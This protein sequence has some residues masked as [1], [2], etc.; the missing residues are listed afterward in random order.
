[1]NGKRLSLFLVLSCAVPFVR[2][3]ETVPR[4]PNV[5]FIIADDL[6]ATALSCYGNTL[7]RTPHIDRLAA[8][9]M[10]FTRATCN[11][12]YCGPSR[13]S[14][15]S[16]YYPH[17]TGVL[18]YTSPRPA[19]GGRATW[20]QHFKNAGYY[21]ARV[22]KVYHMG[23]PGD[24]EA[25]SDGA[26]DPASWTERFNSPGPEWQAPGAGETLEN[27]PDGKKP[28]M[29]GNTFVVVEA[30]GDDRV[31]ADGKTAD[32]AVELLREHAGK[33][34][35]LAV[36][37]V[38]P[39]VPFVAPA[40]YFE[41]F[42]PYDKLA[43]PPKQPGDWDD[44]PKAGINYKTSENMKMDVRRQKKAVGGYYAAV[45]YMDAQVGKVLDALDASGQADN[46]IVIFTGDNGYHLGEHDFWA[47]V[48]L[49]D[50]SSQVP[51]IIRAPGKSPGVCR[52]L[53][54]L[55][56]LYPTTARLSGLDVPARLQ[57]KDISALLDDPARTVRE[58][59]FSVAPMRDGFLLR[60]D[61]WAY[62]QYGEDASKGIELFDMASDPQQFT[63]LASRA[64][65][66]ERVAAFQEKLAARLAAVR[67]CDLARPPK[68][69]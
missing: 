56:D 18:G 54:E 57:G 20:P 32:R 27:N 44:I 51:L 3:S 2:A 68:S 31:H 55:L 48:S 39:H 15:M 23:V 30:E 69:R 19:I 58:S 29:G 35:F 1:M 9:G 28:V 59:A 65:C 67:E 53:V 40:T 16:G 33:P 52:S 41:P 12:T 62:I 4:P 61:Q 8:R 6:T 45:S 37:F 63:N 66:A 24:I 36:G 25:G 46:T 11:A 21:S 43:L 5:L 10:R 64:E 34:F 7:C 13:A 47:K 50:E 38:R 60:E 14:F 22:G 17:A 49:R 26:D 42:L